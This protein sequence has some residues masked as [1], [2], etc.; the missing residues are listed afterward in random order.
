[1]IPHDTLTERVKRRVAEKIR[2]IEAD[3]GKGGAEDMAAYARQVGT[4]RGL[5]DAVHILGEVA[6]SLH[7]EEDDEA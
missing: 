7:M 2:A 5:T 6:A 1:M 4:I 3:L